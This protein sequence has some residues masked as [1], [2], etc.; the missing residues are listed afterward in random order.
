MFAVDRVIATKL[1]ENV[2]D[3]GEMSKSATCAK[4]AQVADDG[5]IY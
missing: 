1:L 3:N 4:I 2:Y 5:K